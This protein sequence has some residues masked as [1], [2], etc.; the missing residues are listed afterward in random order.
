MRIP[1]IVLAVCAA[2]W[3]FIDLP[4]NGIEW[5]NNWLDPVFAGSL[6]N[7]H[8]RGATVAALS[9][10]DAVV[11]VAGLTIAW[12]L[13]RGGPT[14]PS[15]NPGSSSGSGT[16]TTSTTPSSAGR[17]PPW[18]A[19]APRWSTSQVIDGGGQ[20]GGHADPRVGLGGPATPDRLRPQLRPGHRSR[21][22]RLLGLHGHEDVVVVSHGLP[23]PDRPG[24]GAGGRR[25]GGGPH[26]QRPPPGPPGGGAG[27]V[28]GHLGLRRGR[29]R[30]LS[31]GTGGYQLTSNHVWAQ[32]LGHPLVRRR[33]RHLAVP[34]AA[35]RRAVPDR[36]RRGVQPPGPPGL[37][38]PGCSSWRLPASAASS[39]ST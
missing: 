31:T 35:G 3:G 32:G 9:T 33:R 20:R 18:P 19:S 28:A 6:Y 14:G 5:F 38:R 4:I 27:G 7:D 10:T 23:L 2:F 39:R 36:A 34:G 1:L 30:G 37:R 16:G 22:G 17:A 11:A 12:M 26:G 21:P 15:S 29:R 25:P 8:E 13:W 24:P